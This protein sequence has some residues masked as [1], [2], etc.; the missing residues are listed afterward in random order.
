MVSQSC[1][2]RD[3]LSFIHQTEPII[4][5]HYDT[6]HSTAHV[7][8]TLGAADAGSALSGM[9]AEGGHDP[10][11]VQGPAPA[12]QDPEAADVQVQFDRALSLIEQAAVF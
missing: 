1:H 4:L 2:V 10:P 5:I 8:D 3:H 11:R 6:A 7:D 9:A 12:E